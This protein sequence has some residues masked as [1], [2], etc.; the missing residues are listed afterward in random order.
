M[1]TKREATGNHLLE[2]A[3]RLFR[4]K[5]FDRTT[6]RDIAEE[7]G[8]S[9]GATYYHFRSK[10]DLV[11]AF[12]RW[13]Q[14]EHERLLRERL[15]GLAE[16]ADR[17]RVALRSKLELVEKSRPFLGALFRFTGEPE[18]PLSVFGPQTREIRQRAI[19]T[20]AFALEGSGLTGEAARLAETALWALHLALILHAVHD[21][22]PGMQKTYALA[23]AAATIVGRMAL[24]AQSPTAAPVVAWLVEA[25]AVIGQPVETVKAPGR[26]KRRRQP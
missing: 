23:D 6:M 16:P 3:L 13:T 19:A 17:V 20:F 2:T 1:T 22:S 5:G 21:A 25:L 11:L 12:Y 10:E 26:R 24:L 15:P 9:V 8:L 7:A 18:H 14:D 4:R